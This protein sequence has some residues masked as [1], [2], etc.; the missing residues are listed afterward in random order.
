MDGQKTK[1]V[2]KKALTELKLV[3]VGETYEIKNYYNPSSDRI[4][5]EALIKRLKEHGGDAKKA[6]ADPFYKP[7]ASGEQGPLVKK[8]KLE[9]T[10]TLSVPVYGGNG[11]AKNETMVR[12][13]VFYVTG[14]GYY[15]VPIY[16]ADTIKSTLPCKG[17]VT[18]RGY[19]QWKVLKDDEF[20]FSLYP[21]DL[22]C[23]K[24]EKPFKLNLCQK[25]ST[26]EKERFQTEELLY[27]IGFDISTACLKGITNDSTY[28]CRSI[29][30]TTTSIEKYEVDVLGNYHKVKKE[31]RLP[32]NS[33]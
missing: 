30:K 33:K 14:E 3:Q 4:L 13:D 6:F 18:K 8:V 9:E 19:S 12:L 23:I 17:C 27:Y 11:S 28:E 22:I 21:N 26:L 15:F 1:V 24:R 31:K 5:Y 10:T 2:S 29:G 32:F 7:T 25:E 20:S 16:V